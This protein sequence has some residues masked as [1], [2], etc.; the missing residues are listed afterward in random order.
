MSYFIGF[1]LAL[2]FG[3]FARCSRLD[4]DRA[5]YPTVMIVI[6]LLY[7]LFT[8]IDGSPTLMLA[9]IGICL[10]FVALA[11]AGFKKSLWFVVVALAAHGAFDFVHP[12]VVEHH[13]VPVF[14]PGFC[15]AYDFT[16]AALLAIFLTRK[17][18]HL[19]TLPT[20]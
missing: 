7:V 3:A 18:D 19:A 6:G 14:W 4:R 8:A 15:S 5:F 13:G 2:A 12:H 9:E 17:N 10:G 16:A 11:V 20:P 1:V